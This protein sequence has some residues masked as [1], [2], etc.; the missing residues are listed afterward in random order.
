MTAIKKFVK[1]SSIQFQTKVK[2][3]A[4]YPMLSQAARGITFMREG[5]ICMRVDVSAYQAIKDLKGDAYSKI[6]NTIDTQLWIINLQTG[7]VFVS[8]DVPVEWI[9]LTV[10]VEGEME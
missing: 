10:D 7:R 1:P 2:P 8:Q 4:K 3:E 6:K 5:A 9:K